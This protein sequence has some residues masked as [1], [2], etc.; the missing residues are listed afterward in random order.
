MTDYRT[1]LQLFAV[2]SLVGLG[3]L[4]G[5]E[6][7]EI[8]KESNEESRGAEQAQESGERELVVSDNFERESLGE[9]WHRGTGENGSGTWSIEDGWLQASNIK[10]DPLWLDRK[11]PEK[12]R[13][14][15]DARARSSEGDLKAEIFGDGEHHATGYILIMGGWDNQ[16][17]VVARLDEHGDDR[18]EQRSPGVAKGKVYRWA[19]ERTDGTLRWY[20]DGELYM[21]YPDDSP[22]RGEDHR[23]FAFNDWEAPV[24]FDNL[25]IYRLD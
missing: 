4:A 17:D 23:Y 20:V 3:G 14:E 25:R 7:R 16:L 12:V 10:N 15:F 8:G 19:I 9:R 2:I 13:V 5:C 21:S 6:T 24:A 22:L 18:K 1:I 11:L